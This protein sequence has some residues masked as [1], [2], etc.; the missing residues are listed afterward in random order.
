MVER[1]LH[2]GVAHPGVGVGAAL[3]RAHVPHAAL[4]PNIAHSMALALSGPLRVTALEGFE[5]LG[6]LHVHRVPHPLDR[7][8]VGDQPHILHVGDGVQEGDETFLVVRGGEPGGVVEQ[9]HG[10]S[11]GRVMTFEV[12]D[13]HLVDALSIRGRGT[14]VAHGAPPTVQVLPHH[15]RHLPQPWE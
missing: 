2:T 10:R 13:E 6:L 7:L 8:P 1:G 5:A 11:V 15:H 3:A 9:T 4:V 14:G 12:L